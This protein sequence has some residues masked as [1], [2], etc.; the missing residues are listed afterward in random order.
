MYIHFLGG[1]SSNKAE[2]KLEYVLAR[3]KELI[4]YLSDAAPI[5]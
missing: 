2:K 1:S 4:L 3:Y 5:I